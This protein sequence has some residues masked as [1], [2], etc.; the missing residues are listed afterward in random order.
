M[1]TQLPQLSILNLPNSL[2]R[3]VLH[4]S[5]VV[6]GANGER[7]KL[8]TSDGVVD[9]DAMI[10]QFAQGENSPNLN[11]AFVEDVLANLSADE[12]AE[13]PICLDVMQYPMVIPGCLHQWYER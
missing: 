3:A 12:N 1:F 8:S 5:L 4:P 9:I 11:S 2:R 10:Q 7:T 13:C 6:S